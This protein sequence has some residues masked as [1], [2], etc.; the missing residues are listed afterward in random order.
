MT[1]DQ[2]ESTSQR[3]L[4]PQAG[5]AWA[6]DAATSGGTG[7]QRLLHVGEVPAP[8]DVATALGLPVGETVVVRQRLMLLDDKPVELTD[9]YYP[10]AIAAGTRLAEARKVP[11][12]TVS[13]LTQL[14]YT[15]HDV[16]EEITARLPTLEEQHAL[17]LSEH[18]PVMILTRLSINDSGQPYEYNVMTMVAAGRRLQYRRGA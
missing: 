17:N 1:R 13:L 2:W 10:T 6:D 16:L 14:G 3:Y 15:P 7:T 8:A 9:S 11:G 4:T 18:E 12:G 5:D